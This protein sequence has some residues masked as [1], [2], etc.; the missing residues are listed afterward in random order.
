M[1]SRYHSLPL[2]LAVLFLASS[3]QTLRVTEVDPV[4]YSAAIEALDRT[5]TQSVSALG[6]I[7]FESLEYSHRDLSIYVATVAK[8][9]PTTHPEAFPTPDHV[10][11][12]HI[13][14][15]NALA[16]Y[17]AVASGYRP[18]QKLAFFYRTKFVIAGEKWSLYTYENKV[19]RPLGDPRIHFA[20]NC[21][22]RSCPRLPRTVFRPE[23]LQ[24]QLEEATEE[25]VNA[26]RHVRLDQESQTVWLSQILK[27]YQEDFG[28]DE[29][30]LLS[31]LNQYRSE[32]IPPEVD[33]KYLDYNW[34]LNSQ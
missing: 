2:C 15:Y 11:A 9:S 7:D 21:M 34:E 31:Y 20:L 8:I 3:C 12:F 29:T 18:E 13:N 23:A 32:P 28:E 26:E 33:I 14:T 22:V 4:G 5:L 19:I 25:F 17:V 10:L 6:R 30:T 1:C 27:W 24:G 16:L